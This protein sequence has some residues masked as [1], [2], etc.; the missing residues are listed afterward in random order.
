M[1]NEGEKEFLFEIPNFEEVLAIAKA[2]YV[3]GISLNSF[4]VFSRYSIIFSKSSI[5]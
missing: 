3:H 4:R 2:E 1:K 5:T